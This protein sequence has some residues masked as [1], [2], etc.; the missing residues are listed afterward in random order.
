MHVAVI[1]SPS[2]AIGPLGALFG[3]PVAWPISD[4]FGR[5]P[6]LMLGSI[7]TLIGWLAFAYSNLLPTRVGFLTLLYIGRFLSGFGA[8]WTIFCVSVSETKITETKIT[9]IYTL[10]IVIVYVSTAY[11]RSILLRYRHRS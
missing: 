11:I 9:E 1:T 3:G 7:P 6:A 2:Q 8:G 4:S 5:K 10:L